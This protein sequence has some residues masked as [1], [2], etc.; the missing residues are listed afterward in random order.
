MIKNAKE[1][2]Y[3]SF[4]NSSKA[5]GKPYKLIVKNCARVMIPESIRNSNGDV[6]TTKVETIWMFHNDK[7]PVKAPNF[8]D[9]I[10]TLS[11]EEESNIPSIERDELQK[12]IAG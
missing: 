3:A 5:W 10:P 11:E 4:I 12:Y 9:H 7:F 6:S 2:A 1:E 8:D